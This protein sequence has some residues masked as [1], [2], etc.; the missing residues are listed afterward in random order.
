[1]NDYD[2]IKQ[3]GEGTYGKV[4]RV[5]ERHSKNTKAL[6][7]IEID[8]NTGF[9]F[10]TIREIK[11]MK[12]LKHINIINLIDV[13]IKD[14]NMYMV[15]EYFPY[16]LSALIQAKK[17]FSDE[18]IKSFTFQLLEAVKYVH[19]F[20]LVHRDIKTSNILIDKNGILKLADFG[21]TTNVK[22]LQNEI[23]D[24][25]FLH[26]T[27]NAMTNRV[28]TLWYRAP[29]LLLGSCNYDAKVDSWSIGCVILEM[30]MG[31]IVFR[32][33]DEIDQ[34]RVVFGMLGCPL[35]EYR[36][37]RLFDVNQYEKSTSWGKIMKDTFGSYFDEEMLMFVGEFLKLSPRERIS[38]KNA[39]ILSLLKDY[40]NKKFSIQLDDVHDLYVG[41][42]KRKINLPGF[43]LPFKD[44]F[45]P[46]ACGHISAF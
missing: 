22:T 24:T 16:D 4:Y 9:P 18:Q 45:I 30:K 10:T 20:G 31:R 36:W 34:T 37:S 15:M 1:M 14:N 38:P 40:G 3:I 17:S 44:R 7:K 21:L 13:Y 32:G 12:K 27:N 2:E 5:K 29:E 19:S 39:L 46:K 8:K 33:T 26:K 43:Y 35:E 41:D 28:C 25:Q 6:K 23:L 42:R 11:I